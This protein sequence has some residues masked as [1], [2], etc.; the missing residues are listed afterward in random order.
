MVP[1][2]HAPFP[3]KHQGVLAVA[4][5]ENPVVH[6]EGSVPIGGDG[7]VMLSFILLNKQRLMTGERLSRSHLP[8]GG[9]EREV[10]RIFDSPQHLPL[11][12]QVAVQCYPCVSPCSKKPWRSY[13]DGK[14][15]SAYGG[16]RII[17][18]FSPEPKRQLPSLEGALVVRIIHV[19]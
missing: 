1:A 12:V 3:S 2:S 10:R 5:I 9:C 18:P 13:P 17:L 15:V 6:H 7:L 16:P 4:H 8:N 11:K 19:R 14:A